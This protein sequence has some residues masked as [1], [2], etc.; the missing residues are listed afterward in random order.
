MKYVFLICY[1]FLS[2]NLYSQTADE[3]DIKRQLFEFQ[4]AHNNRNLDS[5]MMYVSKNYKETFMPDIV[6]DAAAFRN[7]YKSLIENPDY[8]SVINYIIEDVKTSS[9][10]GITEVKWNYYIFPKKSND[11]LYYSANKGVIYWINQNNSWKMEKAFGGNLKEV[12]NLNNYSTKTGIETRILDWMG[13]FENKDLSGVMD[14][15]DKEV[16]GISTFNGGFITYEDLK[17]E[18]KSVFE[19]KNLVIKYEL[20][21]LE[22]LTFSDDLAYSISVWVYNV[23]DTKK[24]I[25]NKSNYRHLS[26]WE[27]QPD[28]KWKIVSFVHKEIEKY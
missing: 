1:I 28:G 23:Y 20:D 6:Y 24:D 15:Y 22:E 12:N 8:R 14:L 13:Y 3:L 19:N 27:Q 21:G 25:L 9:K 16:K 5:M 26:V 7:Y 11:T 18:Y 4:K 2:I 17:H 10:T